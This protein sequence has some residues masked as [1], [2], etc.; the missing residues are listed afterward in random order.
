MWHLIV[1]IPGLCTLTYFLKDLISHVLLLILVRVPL[2]FILASCLTAIKTTLL[3]IVKQ[4]IRGMIKIY[5]VYINSGEILNE[6]IS[7]LPKNHAGTVE[8]LI[9]DFFRMPKKLAQ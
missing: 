7:I 8:K 4:F 9:S 6:L 5:F 3:N 1:S 2:S